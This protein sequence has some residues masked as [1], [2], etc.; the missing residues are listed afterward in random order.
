[1]FL[2]RRN[3][4]VYLFEK[5]YVILILQTNKEQMTDWKKSDS[6]FKILYWIIK[7]LKTFKRLKIKFILEGIICL[8]L[9]N[10]VY[11]IGNVTYSSRISAVALY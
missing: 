2:V 1:M 11:I 9:S 4:T 10:I 3:K 7:F 8:H 5:F 6:Y